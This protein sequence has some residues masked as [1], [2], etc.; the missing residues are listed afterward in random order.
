MI[1]ATLDVSLAPLF[2]PFSLGGLHLTNRIVMAPMTRCFAENGVPGADA[3]AYYRRRARNGVGLIMSEGIGVDHPSALGTGPLGEVNLPVL[4]SAAA[5][6][7]WRNVVEAVHQERGAIFAQLWH[8]GVVRLPETGPQPD[9]PSVSP[10]GLWGPV[11]GE[12]SAPADYLAL[13]RGL[14]R[15]PL[16]ESAISDIIDAYGRSAR[17][18]AAVGFDGI[19]LHGAHGYLIDSFLWRETN[20]RQDQWGGCIEGRV[21]FAV[22]VVKA[23]RQ[24]APDLPIAFR[25]SQWKLQ[26]YEARLVDDADGLEKILLPLAEAGVDLFDAS[27][28]LFN[29]PAFAGSSLT[30]AGWAKAI[31]G[32]PAMAVG[33]VGLDREL[34]ETLSGQSELSQNEYEAADAIARGEFDLIGVGRAL[35]ADYQW[36]RKLKRGEQALPF[37]PSCLEQLY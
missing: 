33:G 9:A 30:L 3:V 12:T 11:N 2:A 36:A 24:A 6:D 7:G 4:N 13:M 21:R 22:E 10:S 26:D 29:R 23:V 31:T 27:T 25:F 1:A 32:K 17:H 28:R 37:A 18:A 19:A 14:H 34:R 20:R 15:E 8:Q 35:I 5:R 16:S